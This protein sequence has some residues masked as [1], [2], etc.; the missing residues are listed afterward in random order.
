MK[1]DWKDAPDWANWLAMDDDGEWYWYSIEPHLADDC[2]VSDASK[3]SYAGRQVRWDLSLS[4][5]PQ[6][7][8]PAEAGSEGQG[9]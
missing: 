1:P 5:R 9:A 4:E 6:T 7:T 3:L 2:W 8:K